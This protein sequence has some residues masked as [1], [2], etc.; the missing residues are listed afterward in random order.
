ML[1]ICT[2]LEAA[3]AKGIVHRDLKPDNIFIVSDPAVPGGERAKILDFGIAKLSGD[4]P[5]NQTRTDVLIGTPTYMS[6]EQCRGG[7]AIDHRS[8]IYAIGCVMFTMLTG[9]PPFDGMGSGDLIAAHL[10]E[11]PPLASSRIPELPAIIDQILQKCLRKAPA[12]RFQSM[13]ELVRGAQLR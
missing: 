7:G 1:L 6:P 9:R 5:G 11:A 2:S 3:H 13:S 4:E 10:R 12:E 8:D